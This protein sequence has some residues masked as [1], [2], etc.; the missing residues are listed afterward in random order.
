MSSAASSATVSAYAESCA[1]FSFSRHP[2]CPWADGGSV[3]ARWSYNSRPADSSQLGPPC[4][5][6]VSSFRVVEFSVSFRTLK[7]VN[8]VTGPRIDEDCNV[9]HIDTIQSTSI[10]G[11]LDKSVVILLALKSG[12]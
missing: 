9:L 6:N 2:G 4:S 12:M 10:L 5:A 11:A 3:D 7:S 1:S 8:F